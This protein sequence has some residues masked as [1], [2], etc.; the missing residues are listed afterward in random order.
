MMEL[1]RQILSVELFKNDIIQ[2]LNSV[3]VAVLLSQV[4]AVFRGKKHEKIFVV[5][6]EV[7]E[8]A[9]QSAVPVLLVQ[10]SQD[11]MSVDI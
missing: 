6:Q 9:I 2:V 10:V 7:A 8:V 3:K 11:V 1:Q 4:F 5:T